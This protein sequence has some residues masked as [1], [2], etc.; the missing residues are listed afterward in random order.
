MKKTNKEIKQIVIIAIVL[1][2]FTIFN[3]ALIF[4]LKYDFS[5]DFATR[6]FGA[7]IADYILLPF[8]MFLLMYVRLSHP[9]KS[10]K[11]T[12]IIEGIVYWLLSAVPTLFLFIH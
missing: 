3:Y 4:V 2:F 5:R 1:L 10:T 8:L 12:V 11:R 6:A 9:S 7:Y